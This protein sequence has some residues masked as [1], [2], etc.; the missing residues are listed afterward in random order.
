MNWPRLDRLVPDLCSLAAAVEPDRK[1]CA[2]SK[3]EKKTSHPQN[4]SD[5]SERREGG[6]KTPT[7]DIGQTKHIEKS[8]SAIN[9]R[10]RNFRCPSKEM[11]K[12]WIHYFTKD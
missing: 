7:N 1:M 5:M 11:R 2:D 10:W 4:Q 3:E 9:V 6:T 8:P 12:L